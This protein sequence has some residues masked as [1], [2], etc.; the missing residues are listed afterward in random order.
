MGRPE[1]RRQ[2]LSGGILSAGVLLVAALLAIVNYFGFKYY[3]RFDWT[4]A[5]LYTLSEKSL[6]ADGLEKDVEV[7][8]F[9]RPGSSSS[10]RSTSCSSATPPSP[11]ASRSGWSTRTRVLI[12]A[13]QLVDKYQVSSLSV[14]VFDG[15]DDRRVIEETDLAEYLLGHAVRRRAADDRVQGRGGVHRRV[16]RAGREPQADDPLHHRP[17]RGLAR[18]R[19]AC[20]A[21]AGPDAARQGELRDAPLGPARP[22][23]RAGRHGPG[24]RRGPAGPLRRA[25]A[26]GAR[27][28][29]SSRAAGCRRCSTRRSLRA[30]AAGWS[31]PVSP[32]GWPATACGSA[33]TSSSTRRIRCRSMAPRPSSSRPTG[34]TR[35]SV[36]SGRRSSR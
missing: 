36:R 11:H 1:I 14:V 3:H 24:G 2:L 7:V 16:A 17:W 30:R 31:T 28:A 5:Q 13:Q 15:G 21:V 22:G 27:S 25:G 20:R 26:R 33:T 19:L 10:S 23:R 18:R 8:V 29:T 6:G 4:R 32:P 12:E 9:M 34:R 35:S